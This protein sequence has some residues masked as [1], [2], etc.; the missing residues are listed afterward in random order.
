MWGANLPHLPWSPN[1]RELSFWIRELSM[2]GAPARSRELF[3][4]KLRGWELLFWNR[5]PSTAGAP[6]CSREL[7]LKN[8]AFNYGMFSNSGGQLTPRPT[9]ESV[10]ESMKG[11]LNLRG[12]CPTN[13]GAR[14]G[15]PKWYSW[16]ADS[17]RPRTSAP[18]NPPRVAIRAEA[19]PL[20]RVP[21][22]RLYPEV[23][24]PA[25]RA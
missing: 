14:R 18:R 2:A 24:N 25:R 10:P 12:R 19:P 4:K 15:E 22:P 17:R 6:T 20:K 16:E 21:D 11:T 9:L 7:L 8:G 3:L 1:D 13:S 5:E 23:R